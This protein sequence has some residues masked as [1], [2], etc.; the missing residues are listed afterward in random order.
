MCVCLSPKFPVIV[1]TSSRTV[2]NRSRPTFP[3]RPFLGA[4]SFEVGAESFVSAKQETT[5]PSSLHSECCFSFYQKQYDPSST[6]ING[7]SCR[8]V[9]GC[10]CNV[11]TCAAWPALS[12]LSSFSEAKRYLCRAVQYSA[13]CIQRVLIVLNGGCCFVGLRVVPIVKNILSRV[14]KKIAA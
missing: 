7:A 3:F 2:R 4:Q 10:R 12:R 13:C 9:F 11:A 8:S 6:G 1:K 14:G 5:N